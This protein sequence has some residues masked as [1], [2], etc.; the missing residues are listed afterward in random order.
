[1]NFTLRPCLEYFRK[2]NIVNHTFNINIIQQ[3]FKPENSKR[4]KHI[5]YYN[6]YIIY[7]KIDSINQKF[8]I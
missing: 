4:L 2:F 7:C 5:F 6:V 1:M 3:G 8:K